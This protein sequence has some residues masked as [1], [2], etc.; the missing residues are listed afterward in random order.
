[1][2][3]STSRQQFLAYESQTPEDIQYGRRGGIFISTCVCVLSIISAVILAVLVGVIVYFITYYKVAQETST[4]EF[5]DDTEPFGAS[6]PS[7]ELRLP[8]SVVPSFYRLKLHTDL[9]SSNFTGEVY[10]TIRANKPVKEI[11]LHSKNLSING[12]ARLTEQIYE[13]VEMLHDRTKRQINETA[14][15]S[16]VTASINESEIITTTAN[17]LAE[18]VTEAIETTTQIV[19]E[20]PV[21]PVD[22]QVTH[23]SV[24]NIKILSIIEATGD[25]LIL[26]LETALTPNVDYTLELPF[27]GQISNSLTGF[28]KSTY[29]NAK[30]ETKKL[31]VTQFEPTSARA[32]F[33]CFDEP[34]FKAMFEISIAHPENI[35]VLSNMKVS[36]E[37]NIANEPGWKWTHFDRSVNMSTYLVAYVLS[38]FKSL[39]TTYLSKDNVTKPIRIWTRPELIEKANYALNIT[40]KLLSYYEEVF[41]VPYALEKLD[42]IAIPDFSSGAMENWGL[43]TFRETTLL[44]DEAESVPRDKQNVAIDIAHELAHQWFG[45]LV[46]MRWW[47]DLWLNEGFATYIEYLGVDHIEPEW[48]MFESF[49][50]DKMD[51]LRSDALKNTSPVSRKVIDASEISQ[52]FDEISYS[53]GANLIRM[54]NHTISEELFHK[55]LVIYLN[56]WKYTNAEENDLWQAME[57]AT[58]TDPTLK[59]LSV[60]NF[61][62]TWTRQAGY[63]VVKVNRNYEKGLIE[64]EQKLFT[65]AL[66]PY[67]KMLDQLWHIPISYTGMD[68]PKDQWNT[69]PRTWLKNRFQVVSV[70][71]NSTEALYVNVD[72]IG[73]YRV[74]YDKKN[75][76]L[77][78]AALKSGKVQSPITKA[79]LIDDAFNLA[80]ASQLNYS[81]ALGLTTCVMNGE[82]SKIVWDLLLNNMGFLKFNLKATAGFVYF[83]D[84]MRIILKKQLE[85]LNYGL[86]KP[87]DD[88]EA[89]LIEN[90]LMWE[91]FVESPR[92]LNW[93]RTEFDKWMSNPAVNPIPSYLRSL[94]YSVALKYGSRREFDFLWGVFQSSADPTVKSL[95][96]NSLPSTREEGLITM[97]LEKSITEIPKQYAIAV[98]SFDATA[99][100]AIAQDFLINNF[101][102]VYDKF[103][104]MDAFMFPAVLSGAFGFISH[105]DELNKLKA[106]A[107]HHKQQLMPMSQ[108]LQKLLDTAKLRINWIDKYA[109][110]INQWFR[111]YVT[112][113]TTL[114]NVTN[115]TTTDANTPIIGA[116]GANSSANVPVTENP[117][118]NPGLNIT[119]VLPSQ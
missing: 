77:L 92:C 21:A 98:W 37:E 5:W 47:T 96:I 100:T 69:K 18:N 40:P 74:N 25:R 113:S 103:T 1:M 55:G 12:N 70:P 102:R 16:N 31:G 97:L 35:S 115:T 117:P 57:K 112:N 68:T 79:Q 116:N 26:K 54:L 85:K 38:D 75:W 118:A 80:K 58:R 15:D 34:A 4:S 9:E 48:N 86:N 13:K 14:V 93:A 101:Q 32:A 30:N 6:G 73:Y 88:N 66:D 84:Y 64:I 28:Y 45:N 111:D 44:F 65:S 51:L 95:A 105:T 94:V 33:P 11:I 43:I 81:Y 78:S 72:A 91:C 27:S 63:P 76:E 2:T 67:Q 56:D 89:L 107:T 61:M 114:T 19:T 109:P 110:S 46:T 29:K 62:N 108:T 7:P 83:Q 3:L 50:R 8:S 20:P 119:E 22:T 24:R 52:K 42:L 71:V 104:Q 10:I 23:S 87:R 53:K 82:D 59:D 90:L 17:V 99:A 106:F 36:T 41:G 39:E 60:V 49:G